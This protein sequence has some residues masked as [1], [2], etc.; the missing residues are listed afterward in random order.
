MCKSKITLIYGEKS[1][2]LKH[3][4][5]TPDQNFGKKVQ[6]SNPIFKDA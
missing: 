4:F 3:I 2:K 5:Y 1:A 6:I